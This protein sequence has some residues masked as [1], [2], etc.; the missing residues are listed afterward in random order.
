M[1]WRDQ[2]LCPLHRSCLTTEFGGCGG[3]ELEILKSVSAVPTLAGGMEASGLRL[4]LVSL[5]FKSLVC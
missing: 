2:G 5:E 4:H 1:G 3:V